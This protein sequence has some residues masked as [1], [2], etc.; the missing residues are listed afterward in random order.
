MPIMT[1]PGS[2]SEDRAGNI[3]E[4]Y[5]AL[6]SR[7]FRYSLERRQWERTDT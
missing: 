5:Y 6:I 4:P 2:Q 3:W 7:P 1:D